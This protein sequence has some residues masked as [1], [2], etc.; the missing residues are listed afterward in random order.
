[1]EK[2]EEWSIAPGNVLMEKGLRWESVL[3]NAKMEEE[4]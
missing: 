4:V 3:E 2:G 1:M